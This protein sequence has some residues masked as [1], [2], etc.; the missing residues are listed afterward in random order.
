MLHEEAHLEPE[1]LLVQGRTTRTF[2]CFER[3]G[4]SRGDLGGELDR[5]AVERIP[6]RF[7]SGQRHLERVVAEIR[8]NKRPRFRN[9]VVDAGGGEAGSVENAPELDVV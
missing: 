6:I 8:K 9:D 3:L 2:G 7:T 4:T 1:A 5:G